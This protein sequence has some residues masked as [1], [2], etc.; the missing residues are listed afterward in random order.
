MEAVNDEIKSLNAN[1]TWEIVDTPHNT[2]IVNCRWVFAIKTDKFGNLSKYK[3]RLVAKGF[4]QEFMVDYNETYAPV[5]R[6]PTFRMMMAFANQNSL[7]VHH[8]DVKTAFLNGELDTEIYMK[9]P[10]G[11]EHP[12]NKVCKLKKS[13]YGLKQSARLWYEKFDK[14]IK[15]FGFRSSHL[16]NCLYVREGQTIKDTIYIVLYVDDMVIITGNIENLNLLKQYIMNAFEMK[17]LKDIELFLGMRITR[18]ED[19]IAI[20]QTSYIKT[21]LEKFKMTNCNP[22]NIPMENRFDCQTLQSEQYYEAPCRSLLGCLIY[23]SICTRPDISV[24]VNLISR[25]VEKNNKEVWIALKRILAYL[26]GTI[27]L[28]LTYR[29][30]TSDENIIS[31]FADA[32]YA[33]DIDCKST[34]GHV[35]QMYGNATIGWTAKKQCAVA[36]STTEA[37]FISLFDCV[38]STL[39]YR[40]LLRSINIKIDR[41][42]PIYEDNQACIAIATNPNPTSKAVHMRV[43]YHYMFETLQNKELIEIKY[44]STELQLSDTLTKPLPYPTF[45]QH[46]DSMNLQ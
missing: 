30:T 22:V 12:P 29:R 42:I 46:R 13:I 25:Y 27:N 45:K 23:I 32:K 34:S 1:N 3:A 4:T 17:D 2:N 28:K 38:N 39:F 9:I 40:E 33:G 20:D 16:D 14:V 44:I 6:I 5:A 36:T 41:P 18:T 11:I 7:F 8:M 24:A 19:S 10:P 15:K 43:K 31:A 35:F 37:E 21:V 26:K